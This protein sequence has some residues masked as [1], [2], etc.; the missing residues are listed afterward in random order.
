LAASQPIAAKTCDITAFGAKPGEGAVNTASIN[1]AIQECSGSGGGTVLIPAGTWYSGT[2]RL[3]SHVNLHLEAG[4][5]LKGSANLDD[6][7]DGEATR[8]LIY[9]R[10]AT[11][12]SI[13]GTGAIDGNG[14]HF[15]D[16]SRAHLSSDFVRSSTRQGQDYMKEGFD[17]SDGPVGYDDRPGMMIVLL[18]SENIQIHGVRMMDSP[19]WTM[20]LGECDDVAIR[21]ITI[22]NNLL[23]PNS[24]GIHCTTS[25]N[26]RISDCDVRAGDDAIIVTGFGNEINVHGESDPTGQQQSPRYGNK[27][28]YAENVT[29]TNSVLQSRSAGIRVGYGQHPIRNCVFS[30]L[31]IYDSN[32]G[33]GVFAR[34]DAD[35]ENI[36][37]SNITIQNRLHSGHWWGNGEPIHVSTIT[38][39]EGEES[40]DVRNVRFSNILIDSESGIVVWGEREAS[41]QNL[42]FND[43]RLKI[44]ASALAGEYGGNF[45][46]RPSA[47]L[48]KSIFIH[49]IP[50]LFA[51]NVKGLQIRGFQ[52]IWTGVADYHSNGIQTDGVSG[53]LIDE[54]SE[55]SAAPGSGKKRLLEKK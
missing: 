25:R 28:G 21:G 55:F 42:E 22:V 4:A 26:V 27:T 20:R 38:R 49:D 32:R 36:L 31:V 41:I 44:G 39:N 46:L 19:S 17:F 52:L 51:R 3:L 23:I 48:S 50:G 18:H 33:I 14:S 54:R 9:A 34:D 10:D 35:I 40:G 11:N 24:D 1:K 13:T 47:D 5:V 8:G 37:F 15:M 29:V 6:Y 2:I 12:I 30:D 53:L 45:D 7:K 43:V 16:F